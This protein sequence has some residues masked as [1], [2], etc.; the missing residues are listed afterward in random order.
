MLWQKRAEQLWQPGEQSL[1]DWPLPSAKGLM[2]LLSWFGHSLCAFQG[3]AAV[4]QPELPVSQPV[5][6]SSVLR[7]CTWLCLLKTEWILVRIQHP[8]LWALTMR[9][10]LWAGP[11]GGDKRKWCPATSWSHLPW[12]PFL[13]R[14]RT[15]S[16][17]ASL[18]SDCRE[19]RTWPVPRQPNF[20]EWSLFLYLV[21]FHI[22]ME[23]LGKRSRGPSGKGASPS[24]S[25]VY[26][27][28]QMPG[29]SS[30]CRWRDKEKESDFD[31]CECT[32]H[33]ENKES[34]WSL[35]LPGPVNRNGANSCSI[36]LCQKILPWVLVSAHPKEPDTKHESQSETDEIIHV[37]VSLLWHYSTAQSWDF[38]VKCFKFRHKTSCLTSP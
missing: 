10:L 28:G 25:P 4:T 34:H 14:S 20:R 19:S 37:H 36:P 35:L 24:S 16:G 17:S 15:S 8:G 11:A 31:C 2:A 29:H 32:A 27:H 26:Q 13:E 21:A 18:P 22:P 7:G 33:G 3:V 23:Q 5:G 38:R 30:H 12:N 9:S 1:T 6:L